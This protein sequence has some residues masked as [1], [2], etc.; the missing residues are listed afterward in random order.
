MNPP[1]NRENSITRY[2]MTEENLM[3]SV[4]EQKA[5]YDLMTV[6]MICLGRQEGKNYNCRKSSALH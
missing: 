4:N 5:D 6:I 1:K 2:Y 3:G